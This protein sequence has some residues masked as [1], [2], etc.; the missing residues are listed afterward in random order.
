[1]SASGEQQL[2]RSGV[3]DGVGI[4]IAGPGRVAAGGSLG[5]AVGERCGALGARTAGLCVVA[6]DGAPVEESAVEEEVESIVS[7][8]GAI[9]VLVLDG[10]ALFAA[11]GGDTRAGLMGC[12]DGAWRATR[13]VVNRVYLA[14]ETAG[15]V[16]YLAPT[17]S[18]GAH[19]QATRAGLENLARTLSIEWSRHRITTVALAP[20]EDT[21]APE[22]ATLTAYLASPAGAYFSGCL[23]DL[24]GPPAGR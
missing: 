16:V 15:R 19:A 3:L 12:L 24:G 14:R 22:V 7:A 20:G 2:L 23:L 21:T 9:D 4:A 6:E 10:A 11:A 13:A 1:M 17:V 5:E 8:L 18:A